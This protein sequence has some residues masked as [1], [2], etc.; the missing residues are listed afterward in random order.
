MV[1][2][3]CPSDTVGIY[4]LLAAVRFHNLPPFDEARPV[5]EASHALVV[6]REGRVVLWASFFGRDAT[7]LDLVISRNMPRNLITK[8]VCKYVFAYGLGLS[9]ANSIVIDAYN[10]KGVKAALQMGFKMDEGHDRDGWVRLVLTRE[11]FERK[12]G[13]RGKHI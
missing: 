11:D 3:A 12:F 8:G 2:V 7:Y 6:R 9:Q 10:P 13:M 5:L 4:E 1:D